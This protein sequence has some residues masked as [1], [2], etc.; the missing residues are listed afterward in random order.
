MS[1]ATRFVAASLFVV[2]CCA[3][4]CVRG[5]AAQP[6]AKDGARAGSVARPAGRIEGVVTD[7]RG[8][9]LAGVAITAQ[10]ARLSYVVSNR[11][12]TFVLGDL[13]PGP[14]VVRAQMPGF[15]ASERSLVNVLPSGATW[16]LLRLQRTGAALAATAGSSLGRPVLNAG[17]AGA[18][19]AEPTDQPGAEPSTDEHD[20]SAK[21]WR[22]RHAKRSV[23]RD[24]TEGPGATEDSA[25][26]G[27]TPE[28][29]QAALSAEVWSGL[30]LSGQVQ[31]LTTT[32][33]DSP[34]QLFGAG[35]PRGVAYVSLS[36]PAG[37]SGAWSVQGAFS[38]GELASWVLGGSYA[39]R[40][41]ARHLIEA[42]MSYATQRDVGPTGISL[43][44]LYDTARN[45]GAMFAL[46]TWQ[47]APVTTVTY[48]ARYARYGYLDEGGLLSPTLSIRWG[49]VPGTWV[50]GTVERETLAPGAEEFVPTPLA[51]MWLPPQR[52]FSP[53]SSQTGFTAERA[54]QFELAL[55]R[56]W[57]S[58][59][60]TAR[61]FRQ[62]VD[63]Q[64]VTLFGVELPSGD[65]QP[66]HYY[67]ADGG[68]LTAYGW[69]I[70]ISRP[71]SS[72]VRGSIAYSVSHGYTRGASGDTEILAIVAPSVLRYT[73]ERLQDLTTVVET[74][75]PETLTRIYA[76]YRLNTGFAS[77]RQDETVPALGTRFDVQV[78]QRVPFLEFTNTQLEV[79]FAVRNL[80]RDIETGSY[81]DELLVVRPP[82]RFVGGV[83]V[84]F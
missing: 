68:D 70:G 51:G 57:A 41:S 24:V 62:D 60:I 33:F 53:L 26:A 8:R 38:Q 6:P 63:D 81:Y 27:T 31:F 69:G 66:G 7:E 10:G 40:V 55:E 28:A 79:L 32:S 15:T 47:V 78:A 16:R 35:G 17:L 71:V 5:V 50:R 11:N 13:E 12:G 80:F 37:E 75:I 3:G 49:V 46:D 52:T 72:R 64:V 74:D 42:G 25:E 54:G 82:K 34:D 23:L 18:S 58:F 1:S 20:D 83:M 19:Q 2:G 21:A 67:T 14:Y 39:G 9:P 36:A 4:I 43:V 77:P 29:G 56:Q 30:P 65:A 61:G 44:S 76:A 59:V 48:G 22:V 45:V 84:R 73:P